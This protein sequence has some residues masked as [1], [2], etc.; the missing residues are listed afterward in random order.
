MV[1]IVPC[2]WK[3]SSYNSFRT[4]FYLIHFHIQ[5][6]N[7]GTYNNQWMVVDYK[8]VNNKRFFWVGGRSIH[9]LLLLHKNYIYLHLE[10]CRV[11][12]TVCSRAATKTDSLRGCYR[13]T[14]ALRYDDC[15]CF[16][17]C[18]LESEAFL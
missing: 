13:H 1:K 9:T 17:R 2:P 18:F 3:V 12:V 15:S 6:F 4:C 16:T 8:K 11:G 7:S 10:K 5:D 14:Y